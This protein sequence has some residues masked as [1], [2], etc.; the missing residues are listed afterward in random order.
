MPSF[1]LR[2]EFTLTLQVTELRLVLKALGGRLTKDEIQAAKEL[3]DEITV[4][5]AKASH[6]AAN[7][8]DKLMRSLKDA[9]LLEGLPP[10]C[11]R[12]Y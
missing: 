4:L 3:G 9:G 7:E 5:R 8:N 2:Q 6:Q 1:N 11:G 12:Q 10:T